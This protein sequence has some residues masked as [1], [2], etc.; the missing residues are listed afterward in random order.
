[1]LNLKYILQDLEMF[2]LS[3]TFAYF[4]KCQGIIIY[5]I[6]T[7]ILLVFY[8]ANLYSCVDDTNTKF[9]FALN[10][11]VRKYVYIYFVFTA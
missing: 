10:I 5:N 3:V 4:E 9:N 6:C 8:L 7:C 11:L 2:S 1:M